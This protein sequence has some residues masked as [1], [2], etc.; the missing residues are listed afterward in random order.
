MSFTNWLT[1]YRKHRKV[2]RVKPHFWH[3]PSMDG[4]S[5]LGYIQNYKVGTRSIRQALTLYLIQQ[6]SGS[7]EFKTTFDD[8]TDDMVEKCDKEHSGFHLPADI[9]KRWPDY[10]IFSFVRHPLS[11]L[12]S[13][14]SDKVVDA[15]KRGGRFPFA[16]WGVTP[17]TTFDEFVKIVA[18]TPDHKSE[19]HFRSQTWFLSENGRLITDFI[20]KIENFQEDWKELQNRFELPSPPHNNRSSGGKS[21][22]GSHFSRESRNLA[23]ERYRRDF[24]LLGYSTDA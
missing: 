16:P 23:V 17:E 18:A 4:Q 13:C 11:R 2:K 5:G 15:A 22:P 10:F 6:E 21:D 20:G 14:Y 8:L 9:K 1:N 24:E 19:R 7:S 12:Y 3:I